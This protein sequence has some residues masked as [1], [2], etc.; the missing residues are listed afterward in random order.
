MGQSIPEIN[1]R[2]VSHAHAAHKADMREGIAEHFWR[3][4][5]MS[6]TAGGGDSSDPCTA[7]RTV[8]PLIAWQMLLARSLMGL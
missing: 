4:T 2:S 5:H 8:T 3:L 7:V 6:D 1:I